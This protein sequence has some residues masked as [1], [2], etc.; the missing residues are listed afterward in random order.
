MK[1]NDLDERV[2]EVVWELED[3]LESHVYEQILPQDHL[4][5]SVDL[6]SLRQSIDCFIQR[7]AV[8]E[9]EFDIELL[10]MPEEEGQP[11][12]SRI[13]FGGID[14]NMV[15]LSK[16]FDEV[17]DDL[18]QENKVNYYAITGWKDNIC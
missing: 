9:A 16:E 6:Q 2:K 15:G 12:S 11:L 3:L 13:D 5:F 7:V 14:S 10:N 17:K 1:V 18:L 8:M 4:S